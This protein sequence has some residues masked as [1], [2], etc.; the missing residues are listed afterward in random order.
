M[1]SL[2]SACIFI[3]FLMQWLS[4]NCSTHA[5]EFSHVLSLSLSTS[6]EVLDDEMKTKTSKFST[7]LCSVTFSEIRHI[8]LGILLRQRTFDLLT[9]T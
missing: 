1:A 4:V 2:C 5:A 9:Q 6:Y 8:I 7:H 3:Y